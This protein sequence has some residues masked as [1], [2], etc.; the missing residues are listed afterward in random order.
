M[1]EVNV[2]FP[3]DDIIDIDLS[4]TRKKKFRFDR[5]NARIVELNTSD[6]N[7]INRISETY[8]KLQSLQVKA[9]KLMEGIGD[10]DETSVMDLKTMSDRL[11]EVDTEMRALI[12]Y[13]F[14]ADVSAKAASDGSMYDPFS[15]SFRF[16][17]IIT[18]LMTQY[19]KNLQQE[20]TEMEKQVT[21]HTDKYIKR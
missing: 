16:E 18:I 6:M 10:T 4:V 12:D 9:G 1:A 14:N 5:D 19:E 7:I 8:P 3:A 17:Y 15:G 11:V 13:M 20:Y 2:N 21:S